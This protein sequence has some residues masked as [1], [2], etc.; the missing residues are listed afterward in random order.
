MLLQAPPFGGQRSIEKSIGPVAVT[1]RDR[2]AQAG[3]VGRHVNEIVAAGAGLDGGGNAAAGQGRLVFEEDLEA[4][5]G[6]DMVVALST[7][8]SIHWPWPLLAG[9]S[10]QTARPIG[11]LHI[12]IDQGRVGTHVLSALSS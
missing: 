5:V 2:D 12:G 4:D 10:A 9:E 3:R 6:A 7:M 8:L 11:V 1:T